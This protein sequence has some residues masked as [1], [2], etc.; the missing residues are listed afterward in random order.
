MPALADLRLT[1]SNPSL[2]YL[3]GSLPQEWGS[4][5]AFTRLSSFYVANLTVQG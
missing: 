5:T 1:A 2:S 4:P 3:S